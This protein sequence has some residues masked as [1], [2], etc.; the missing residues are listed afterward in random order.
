LECALAQRQ[1]LVRRSIR[2]RHGP[3]TFVVVPRAPGGT[4]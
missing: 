4:I 1:E 2:A 3:A